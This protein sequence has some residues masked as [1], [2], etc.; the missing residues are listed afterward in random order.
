MLVLLVIHFVAGLNSTYK[1]LYKLH[2]SPTLVLRHNYKY[3]RLPFFAKIHVAGCW[4]WTARSNTLNTSQCAQITSSDGSPG[5]WYINA[6]LV[7]RYH[8]F[9]AFT[10]FDTFHPLQG[11]IYFP[12]LIFSFEMALEKRTSTPC[13]D[14]N[15][16]SRLISMFYSKE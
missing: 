10:T 4:L 14:P 1:L 6:Y 9:T 7:P 2:R 15:S 11:E 16:P 5:S 13:I 3:E 8:T 12:E